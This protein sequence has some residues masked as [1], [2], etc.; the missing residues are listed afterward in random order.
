MGKLGRRRAK[1][2]AQQVDAAALVRRT[3]ATQR[4]SIEEARDQLAEL[5]RIREE[6]VVQLEGSGM[7]VRDVRYDPVRQQVEVIVEPMTIDGTPAGWGPEAR[8]RLEVIRSE[9]ERDLLAKG[10][11]RVAEVELTR[12]R[13]RRTGLG[14][15]IAAGGAPELSGLGFVLSAAEVGGR[16]GPA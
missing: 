3:A 8:A 15:L 4:I 5:A 16:P 13:P 2:A 1:M 6:H 12:L 14:C 9:M 11:Q 7:M 10:R